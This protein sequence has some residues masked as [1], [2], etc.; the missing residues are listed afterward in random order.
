[1]EPQEKYKLSVLGRLFNWIGTRFL[2]TTFGRLTSL[3]FQTIAS[4]FS[5]CRNFKT[6]V[7]NVLMQT[8]F[9][10]V[11][12]F[13]IL[14]IVSLLFGSVVIIETLSLMSKIG[15]TDVFGN[16]L[17]V[18]VIRELGPIFTAFLI[19]GRSGS[20]LTTMLGGMQN[21]YEIDALSTMGVNPIRYLVMPALFGGV[22]AVFI[23]TVCFNVCAIGGGFLIARTAVS[24]FGQAMNVQ[25]TW[26]FFSSAILQALSFTDFM[27]LIIKP[28]IFGMII[29]INACY[30]GFRV[31]RDVRQLPKATSRSV[32]YSFLY[33]VIADAFLAVFYIFEYFGEIS[34][35]I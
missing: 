34:K 13:P 32:V 12:I 8:F 25:L 31:Q 19:A 27:L 30:Q 3:L 33:I 10:G 21:N 11:E 16:V 26:Q 18:V 1:M 20:A 28:T 24:L 4:L 5:S 2:K 23:M 22:I 35:I 7:H 17:T 29:V 15:F 9:T 6:D 14:F